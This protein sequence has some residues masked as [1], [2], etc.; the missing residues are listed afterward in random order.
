MN[1][2]QLSCVLGFVSHIF[3]TGGLIA[4]AFTGGASLVI[5]GVG[6]TFS[7]LSLALGCG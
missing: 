5:A 2:H 3:T 6:Y 4:A 1:W 7:G